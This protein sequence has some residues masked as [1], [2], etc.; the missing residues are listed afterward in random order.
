[1]ASITKYP[2]RRIRIDCK[3]QKNLENEE[4]IAE[5]KLLLADLKSSYCCVYAAAFKTTECPKWMLD[6]REDTIERIRSLYEDE[7]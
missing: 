5:D 4:K 3:D 7:P 1:M 2:N 6:F